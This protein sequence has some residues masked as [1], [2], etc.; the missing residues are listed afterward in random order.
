MLP[1]DW[2]NSAVTITL[3]AKHPVKNAV[4]DHSLCWVPL[5]RKA[6][7]CHSP[8]MTP[9]ISPAQ[10]GANFFCKRGSAKP[11]QPNSSTGP[12]MAARNNSISN[13][14]RDTNGNGSEKRFPLIAEPPMK[15][16]GI[17]I[18][19]KAYQAALHRQS[20]ALPRKRRRPTRPPL[21]VTRVNAAIAGAYTA[22]KK[23]GWLLVSWPNTVSIG[24]DRKM[25][26]PR[27]LQAKPN[28]INRNGMNKR[29][30]IWYILYAVVFG[31]MVASFSANYW[32]DR[33][34]RITLAEGIGI[35]SSTSGLTPIF[36]VLSHNCRIIQFS[37]V[38]W[39]N[40]GL[41]SG[42][43]ANRVKLLQLDTGLA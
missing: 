16:S 26:K 34:H 10:I 33:T 9:R 1:W 24:S 38:K 6:G 15:M 17:P 30:G 19:R 27:I 13:A 7:K 39:Q 25:Y 2:L 18:I 22:R 29:N 40:K 8:H 21:R 36:G 3:I 28:E 42:S 32:L 41:K 31:F 43:L 5:K 11:R 20:K 37:K 14:W 12:L 4:N 35:L 23:S